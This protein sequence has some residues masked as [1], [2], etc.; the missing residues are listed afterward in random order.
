[1][2]RESAWSAPSPL[3]T[4]RLATVRGGN[5]VTRAMTMLAVTPAPQVA[6]A[7]ALLAGPARKLVLAGAHGK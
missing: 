1:M 3:P 7:A 2:I 4:W 5:V 6:L